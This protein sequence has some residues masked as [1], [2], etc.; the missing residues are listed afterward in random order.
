MPSKQKNKSMGFWLF[1]ALFYVGL[2]WM[3]ESH[4]AEKLQSNKLGLWGGR[5]LVWALAISSL[6]E[7]MYFMKYS[8]KRQEGGKRRPK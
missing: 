2:C 3:F 7:L 1:W 4:L 8:W 6:Y 5:A